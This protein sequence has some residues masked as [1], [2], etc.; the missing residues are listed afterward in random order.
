MSSNIV[1][2]SACAVAAV[3]IA[4]LFVEAALRVYNSVRPSPIFKKEGYGRFRG[5]PN[6]KFYDFKL[7]SRGFLDVE[8]AKD[9][10]PGTY[11]I[12]ALGDSF[13]KGVVPYSRNFLTL[14]EADLRGTAP[15]EI[16]NM[17]IS[18]SDPEGYL[19]LLSEEGLQLNPD[20]AMV[21]FFVGNDIYCYFDDPPENRAAVS[22]LYEMLRF[23]YVLAKNY[24]G[25]V[26]L[27]EYND[28]A[29]T[30]KEERY[31]HNV[32]AN[33]VKYMLD[34]DGTAWL[35][36]KDELKGCFS[37][38]VRDLKRLK[39]K[40][41]EK[42]IELLVVLIPEEIQVSSA[43]QRA[44]REDNVRNMGAD[45][46]LDLDLPNAMLGKE[47]EAL[48]ISYIDLLGVFRENSGKRLYKPSDGHWN[49]EG[50][51]LAASVL[52]DAILKRLA[53]KEKK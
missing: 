1:N 17:G 14:L 16:I 46:R 38:A 6:E 5:A 4:L 44:A 29:H 7:N 15:V 25:G 22:Y 45:T 36:S 20:M 35:S 28:D 47:L 43:L 31:V 34:D 41:L 13:V 53:P 40:C 42:G 52:C 8:Y 12:L 48:D 39:E 18:G 10:T 24:T 21:F 49:I 26:S 23:I 3:A 27:S 2:K 19:D 9:K 37:V 11:R 30:F 50:N 51:R 32:A 33:S